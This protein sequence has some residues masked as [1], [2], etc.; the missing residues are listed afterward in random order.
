MC[1]RYKIEQGQWH[2]RLDYKDFIFIIHIWGYF[3]RNIIY[4]YH[5][6]IMNIIYII[7][8]KYYKQ[9]VYLY[10]VM[11]PR[12]WSEKKISIL[13]SFLLYSKWPIFYLY[14][15]ICVIIESTTMLFVPLQRAPRYYW[16]NYREHKF[17][18]NSTMLPLHIMAYNLKTLFII[19]NTYT[20]LDYGPQSF[21]SDTSL[22][23]VVI[24]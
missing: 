23:R 22:Y 7:C 13:N 8:S 14:D 17:L 9:I 21:I 5:G 18:F 2:F 12:I 15:V 10:K 1:E 19:M 6:S 24:R 11:I 4:L 20:F 3:I 16:C